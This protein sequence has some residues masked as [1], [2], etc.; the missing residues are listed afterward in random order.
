MR[1]GHDQFAR[2]R[3]FTLVELLVVITIIGTLIGLLLPAVQ[4]ARES[5]R[6]IQCANNLRNLAQAILQHETDQTILPDG[7]DRSM[8]DPNGSQ[9]TNT[10]ALPDGSNKTVAVGRTWTLWVDN[11]GNEIPQHPKSAPFQDWGWAYQILPYLDSKA[12]WATTQ[13][14]QVWSVP[15][16]VHC[17]PS[18]RRPAATL[19]AA[20]PMPSG[21]GMQMF[22][23]T[24]YAANAGVDTGAP[25]TKD[26]SGSQSQWGLGWG[27]MG[28]G[29]DAPIIRRPNLTPDGTQATINPINGLPERSL[30]V[31]LADINKGAGTTLLLGEKRMNLQLL[32]IPCSS[33]GSQ[34]PQPG[35]DS[36]WVN[37]WD[38]DTMRWGFEQPAADYYDSSAQ[39]TW[40]SLSPEAAAKY[41]AFGS[42]HSQLF[43]AALCDGSVRTISF[44]ISLLTFEQLCTRTQNA[45]PWAASNPPLPTLPGSTTKNW[46]WGRPLD[47]TKIQ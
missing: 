10:V 1:Y 26:Q 28:N 21:G 27:M 7:G 29:R 45:P 44:K 47:P 36:G 37:G 35:D 20:R 16:A 13:N 18:R 34:R 41:A 17:C 4:M 3:G 46:P 42:S 40:A 15:L 43:N 5:A 30:P 14:D 24:D 31:T 22:A 23:M 19:I 11:S 6:K 12:L 39:A 25:S 32:G 2:R 9:A 33:D 8:F 38:W